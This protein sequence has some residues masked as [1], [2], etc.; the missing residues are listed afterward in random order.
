MAFEVTPNRIRTG[1][2]VTA[3]THEGAPLMK[4]KA[5]KVEFCN[6]HPENIHLNHHCFDMRFT[7]F[8]VAK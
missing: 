8:M 6:S 2:Y 1:D 4:A 5:E 3:T 7:I